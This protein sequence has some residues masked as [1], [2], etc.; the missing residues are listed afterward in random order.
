M[1]HAFVIY[2][3]KFLSSVSKHKKYIEYIGKT[4]DLN[5][6]ENEKIEQILIS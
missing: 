6:E 3:F 1:N 2:R 4:F 5:L